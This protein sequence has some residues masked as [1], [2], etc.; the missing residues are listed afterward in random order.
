MLSTHFS[1]QLDLGIDRDPLTVTPDATLADVFALLTNAGNTCALPKG[2]NL[3]ERIKVSS[4]VLVVAGE[5][6]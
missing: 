3:V 1:P 5:K 2:E 6:L 4:C